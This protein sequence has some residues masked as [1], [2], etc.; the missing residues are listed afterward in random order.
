MDSKGNSWSPYPMIIETERLIL[1]PLTQGDVDSMLEYQSDPDV[2]RFIPW[3]VRDRSM[4]A[5]SILDL[6]KMVETTGADKNFVF[7]THS[8][9]DGKII[10]QVNYMLKGDREFQREIGYVI[11]PK[12]GGRGY[13]NEALVI[14][15]L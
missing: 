10:G 12:F 7:G 5:Q 9:A 1:R 11:N 4:V 3:P 15:P 14:K 13:V 8:K 6:E 2:I